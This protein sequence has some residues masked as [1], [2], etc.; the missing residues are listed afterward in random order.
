MDENETAQ[1]IRLAFEEANR[2]FRQIDNFFWVLSSFLLIGTGFAVSMAL[3]WNGE[4]CKILILGSSMLL[5]WFWYMNFLK[6]TLEKTQFFIKK[7]NVLEEKLKID[8]LPQKMAIISEEDLSTDIFPFANKLKY[9]KAKY[10][11]WIM[12][13]ISCLSWIIWLLFIIEFIV[14]NWYNLRNYCCPFH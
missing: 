11:S 4:D 9:V 1:N 7:I 5:M 12:T 3:E 13:Y 10:F 8:V 6:D 2:W 14:K